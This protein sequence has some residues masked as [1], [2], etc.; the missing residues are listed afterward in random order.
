MFVTPASLIGAGR[1]FLVVSGQGEMD[2]VEQIGTNPHQLLPNLIGQ[3]NF[4]QEIVCADSLK[5][6]EEFALCRK[7]TEFCTKIYT[8][9]FVQKIKLPN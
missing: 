2:H 4:S 9:V 6:F 8:I 3:I 5:N 1:F 7:F